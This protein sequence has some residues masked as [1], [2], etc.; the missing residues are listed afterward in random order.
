M[1]LHVQNPL[2]SI[3]VPAFHE[4]AN[5]CKLVFNLDECLNEAFEIILVVDSLEDPTTKAIDYLP[6]EKRNK[7]LVASQEPNR[8]PASAI[9]FGIELARADFLLLM[10]G[11]NSD[12]ANDVKHM[13]DLLRNGNHLVVASR[14]HNLGT[15]QGSN[16]FKFILS[17]TASLSLKFFKRTE[18]SDY[19]NTFKCFR[20]SLVKEGIRSK[21]G[22]TIGMELIYLATIKGLPIVEIPTMWEDRKEGATKFRILRWLPSYLFWFIKLM[23]AKSRKGNF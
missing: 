19:S 17:R 4:Q 6:I 18:I 21:R 5:I 1:T 20:K 8:G 3:I 10:Q 7:I 23:S 15:Y 16:I 22:F 14:F 13:I 12:D 2:I 11:D 9:R